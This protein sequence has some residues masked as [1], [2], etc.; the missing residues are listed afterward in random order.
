MKL[1]HPSHPHSIGLIRIRFLKLSVYPIIDIA[2]LCAENLGTVAAW[3]P[4]CL[5]WSG[6]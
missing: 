2:R 3:F 4:G 6:S 1:S 5:Q